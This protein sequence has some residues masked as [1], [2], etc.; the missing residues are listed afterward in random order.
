MIDNLRDVNK[1]QNMQTGKMDSQ[2]DW[3]IQV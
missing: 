1:M 2:M 3:L